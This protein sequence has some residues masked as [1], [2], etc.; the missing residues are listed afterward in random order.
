MPPRAACGRS[1][2]LLLVQEAG[3]LLAVLAIGLQAGDALILTKPLG[4]GILTT[5][6]KAELCIRLLIKFVES[7]PKVKQKHLISLEIGCFCMHGLGITK[8]S[9]AFMAFLGMALPLST[10]CVGD[11]L[12]FR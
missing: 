8:G 1:V 2:S 5:A 3:D 10:F 12:H 4:I 6:A 7:I 9:M 11:F